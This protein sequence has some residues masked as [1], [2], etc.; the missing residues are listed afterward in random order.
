MEVPNWLSTVVAAIVLLDSYAIALEQ[1]V[2]AEAFFTL[3]LVAA[4]FLVLAQREPSTF[5]IGAGGLLLG[6]SATMR[7]AALFAVPVWL[8]YVFLA[9]FGWRA[10]AAAVPRPGA[11]A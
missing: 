4:V 11:T 3:A 7:T 9:R 6:A 5:A 10:V 8:L 1:H 2:L